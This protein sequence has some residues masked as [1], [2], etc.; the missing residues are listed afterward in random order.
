MDPDVVAQ[1]L[2]RGWLSD[3]E[4]QQL[5]DMFREQLLPRAV[6]AAVRTAGSQGVTGE[7]FKDMVRRWRSLESSHPQLR[8][9][10]L[11]DPDFVAAAL[12]SFG[13]NRNYG[14]FRSV[15][16]VEAALALDPSV[17]RAHP[18]VVAELIHQQQETGSTCFGIANWERD[19]SDAAKND[20]DVVAAA[21][22]FELP[23][24]FYPEMVRPRSPSSE[25]LNSDSDDDH[26]TSLPR[27]LPGLLITDP[28][29]QVPWH[30]W[31]HPDVV[32]ALLTAPG[33][34]A[35]GLKYGG[36]E[37]EDYTGSGTEDEEDQLASQMT[38]HCQHIGVE[39]GGC[40][41]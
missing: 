32:Y 16:E 14:L 13:M 25:T 19:V 8:K 39:L 5:P 37:L 21:L 38:T 35:H 34:G 11:R 41:D 20:P 22:E 10:L 23:D 3:A 26:S 2:L 6:V 24:L 7:A 28:A 29:A 17:L 9:R 30:L 18:A 1:A 33:Y 15:A 31:Q 27:H 40:S 4:W 12:K 36:R